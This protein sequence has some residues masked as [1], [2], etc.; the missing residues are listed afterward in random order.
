MEPLTAVLETLTIHV[1]Q[2]KWLTAALTGI[3]LVGTGGIIYLFISLQ[4][5]FRED[6]ISHKFSHKSKMLLNMNDLDSV[7][8]MAQE[9]LKRYPAEIFAHWYLGQAYYRKNELHKALYEFNYIYKIAPAWR[10]KY[11]NPYIYDIKEQ[12]KNSKPEIIKK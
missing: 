11:L 1:Q 10:Q 7:I 5:I 2:I 3:F 12:L 8:E 4:K 6:Q 9:R